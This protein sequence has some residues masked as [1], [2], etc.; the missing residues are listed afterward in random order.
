MTVHLSREDSI[1]FKR[2]NTYL[3]KDSTFSGKCTVFLSCRE[4]FQGSGPV[5]FDL[6]YGPFELPAGVEARHRARDL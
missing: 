3:K 1:F 5:E 2:D 4:L 6:V